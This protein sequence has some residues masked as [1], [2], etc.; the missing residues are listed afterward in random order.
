MA[1][2][3]HSEV[4]SNSNSS[5]I[6]HC[7]N[8]YGFKYG[9]RN[10]E[11]NINLNRNFG[12]TVETFLTPNSGYLKLAPHFEKKK[13]A[14]GGAL[15][16]FST[17]AF[18]LKR[19]FT[20]E[21]ETRT[22]SQAISQGQFTNPKG[23]EFGGTEPTPQARYFRERFENLERPFE[24]IIMVDLHTGLGNRGRLHVLTG[25]DVKTC[26]HEQTFA[27][28]FQPEKEQHLYE[29]NSGDEKGFYQTIGDIN[30]M[31]A[32]LASQKKVVALTFEFGTLGNGP[33]AKADSLSRMWLENQGTHYGFSSP[34]AEKVIR[35][36]FKELFE[37][38][39]HSWQKG[40]LATTREVFARL[41]RRL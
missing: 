39:D 14:T 6:V 8:P 17:L 19:L 36:K 29:F 18:L 21:F 4:P 32:E 27:R 35:Q 10:T 16:K 41:V 37:P 31:I 23:L 12:T 20:K 1:S 38:H 2:K 28:L 30:T 33:L 40:A 25:F 24:E 34:R 9:R 15:H 3:L 11:E 5:A 26:I 22:L 7:L 13:K